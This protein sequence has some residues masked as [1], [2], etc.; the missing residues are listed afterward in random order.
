MDAEKRSEWRTLVVALLMPVRAEYL[1]AG[2]NPL[3]HWDQIQDRVRIASR[4]SES[5]AQ[6]VTTLT[7]NLGLGA[8]SKRRSL[9][10]EA[11]A[12]AVGDGK[13]ENAAFLDFLEEECG[14]LMALANQEA[15]RRREDRAAALAEAEEMER[16]A[17]AAIAEREAL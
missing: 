12:Q 10:T 14:L 9:A 11:L 17:Q 3:K 5:M 1:A 16:E 6:W 15:T 4:T 13:R 7:R 8:P 2:A